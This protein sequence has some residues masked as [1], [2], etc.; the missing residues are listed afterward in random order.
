VH[1]EI[2]NQEGQNN[3][4]YEVAYV[5]RTYAWRTRPI[6]QLKCSTRTHRVKAVVELW[7]TYA[8]CNKLKPTEAGGVACNFASKESC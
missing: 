3:R 8:S 4:R 5:C 1:I 6:G 2:T 7:E